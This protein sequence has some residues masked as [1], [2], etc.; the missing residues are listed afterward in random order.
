MKIF[1]TM[2]LAASVSLGICSFAANADTFNFSYTFS[3]NTVLT[4]SLSGIQNGSF[5]DN[6]SNVHVNFNGT[7]FS[8]V[9]LFSAAW[10]TTTEDWDNTQAAVISTNGALNNFI[11][12]DTNVPTD[13][14]TSNYFFFI[15]DANGIG[16]E[17]F[18]SNLNNGDIADDTPPNASWT[19]TAVTVPV[20]EPETYAMLLAGLTTVSLIARRRRQA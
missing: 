12:A 15:N 1:K 16:R 7:D 14:N 18:A 13:L 6:I 4:G 11:I 2:I 8:G 19:L 17:V 5:I 20:P 9:N 10:N 3:D